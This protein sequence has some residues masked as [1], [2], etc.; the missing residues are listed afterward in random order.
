MM[1]STKDNYF[2]FRPRYTRLTLSA[3]GAGAVPGGGGGGTPAAPPA[4]APPTTS[5][6]VPS[7]SSGPAA[8][9]PGSSAA[10]EP[11]AAPTSTPN[12]NDPN[13]AILRQSHELVNKFGGSEKLGTIS[14]R[15]EQ[16]YG[17][18][19]TLAT[20]LGYTAES[21]E[22]AF[23][24]DPID[25]VSHLRSEAARAEDARN[26]GA[27]PDPAQAMSREL[28]P[29]KS[30]IARQMAREANQT[31]DSGFDNMLKTNTLFADKTVPAKLR[32]A[33]YNAFTDRVKWDKPL[34]QKI[35]A[36]DDAAVGL[37]QHFDAA[38]AGIVEG[39]NE[40][41]SWVGNGGTNTPASGGQPRTAAAAPPSSKPSFSLDD[42][43][44]GNDNA[45]KAMPSLRNFR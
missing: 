33:V 40:Y 2:W 16:I 5:P 21:F 32:S 39:Y 41:G 42:I 43:L 30:H 17:S 4:A 11:T 37:Q 10:P 20:Q 14:Q 38:L 34:Q 19:K 15:Y 24:S 6:T 44:E 1:H 29:I 23:A 18:A 13:I 9:T 22:E 7:P 26:N 27:P 3:A 45:T 36:G 28:A 25:V 31:V 12:P 35:L 8:G